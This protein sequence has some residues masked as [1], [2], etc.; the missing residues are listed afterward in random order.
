MNPLLVVLPAPD[1]CFSLPSSSK[2]SG[3]KSP[4]LKH[5]AAGEGEGWERDV[6]RL[7]TACPSFCGMDGLSTKVA[8]FFFF[9]FPLLQ[10]WD[11]VVPSSGP[12]QMAWTMPDLRTSAGWRGKGSDTN[13]LLISN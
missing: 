9:F 1:M 13:Q 6:S 7:S 10:K 2:A 12:E 5:P 3:C 8:L 11:A 4:L